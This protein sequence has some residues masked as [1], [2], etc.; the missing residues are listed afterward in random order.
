MNVSVVKNLQYERDLNKSLNYSCFDK[1]RL[2]KVQKRTR[3]CRLALW[4]V[5]V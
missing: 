5:R 3:Q 1:G 2:T 4:V